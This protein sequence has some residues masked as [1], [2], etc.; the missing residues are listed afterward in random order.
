MNLVSYDGCA[1]FHSKDAASF[2]RFM[3]NVY[4]SKELVGVCR[5]FF[6]D[7]DQETLLILS[8]T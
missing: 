7:D 6:L 5:T 3:D 2:I 4:N 1:E 8:S